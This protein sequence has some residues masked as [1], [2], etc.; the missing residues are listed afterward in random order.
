MTALLVKSTVAML[1][2]LALVVMARRSRA[3]LRHLILTALFVFLLLLPAVQ[4]IAPVL[5]IPVPAT[6]LTQTIT[7]AATTAQPTDAGQ[8]GDGVSADPSG[9]FRW[10][11]IAARIYLF[12]A[13]FL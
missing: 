1:V 6:T 2:A 12:V 3:S 9:S 8:N 11:S 7:P 5:L 4:A 10:V 13:T